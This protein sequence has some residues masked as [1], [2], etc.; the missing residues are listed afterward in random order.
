MSDSCTQ[1]QLSV[2]R[3]SDD[4]TQDER[5]FTTSNIPRP[6]RAPSTSSSQSRDNRSSRIPLAVGPGTRPN[7]SGAN[8]R[9]S[10]TPRRR[11]PQ[12]GGSTGLPTHSSSVLPRN[13]P[14]GS[15]SGYPRFI[16]GSA[17]R[18]SSL[19]RPRGAQRRPQEDQGCE[20][21]YNFESDRE[22]GYGDT[23]P[24]TSTELIASA[25]E[26]TQA[27]IDAEDISGHPVQLVLL[28][29]TLSSHGDVLAAMLEADLAMQEMMVSGEHD[30]RRHSDASVP[31][32]VMLVRGASMPDDDSPLTDSAKR[33]LQG[34]T[35]LRQSSPVTRR[36]PPDQ[37][38]TRVNVSIDDR[39]SA[40]HLH[41]S[42]T[43]WMAED[44]GN[45][46]SGTVRR[47][48]EVVQ[49]DVTQ[50]TH[51][52]QP[53]TH[54]FSDDDDND[55]TMSWPSGM[56][57]PDPEATFM[58]SKSWG[59]Q[60]PRHRTTQTPEDAQTQTPRDR[61][62]KLPSV[63]GQSSRSSLDLCDIDTS[64][65]S[66]DSNDST[67]MQVDTPGGATAPRSARQAAKRRKL[68]GFQSEPPNCDGKSVSRDSDRTSSALMR[69]MRYARTDSSRTGTEECDG[70][71]STLL[72]S[73]KD[74]T[75][76][77]AYLKEYQ[78]YIEAFDGTT[79]EP[80]AADSCHGD[81]LGDAHKMAAVPHASSRRYVR[82]ESSN[83][84][85]ESGMRSRVIGSE[86]SSNPNISEAN[87]GRRSTNGEQRVPR[88]STRRVQ[89]ARA[90]RQRPSPE[91]RVQAGRERSL[92]WH[93]R[94]QRRSGTSR[95]DNATSNTA[96][97]QTRNIPHSSPRAAHRRVKTLDFTQQTLCHQTTQTPLKLRFCIDGS[98]IPSGTVSLGDTFVI[99]PN[100]SLSSHAIQPW[101]LMGRDDLE[102]QASRDFAT[103]TFGQAYQQSHSHIETQTNELGL[104]KSMPR[105]SH[106][107][108]D[109]TQ[110]TTNEQTQTRGE[111]VELQP[112]I[113]IPPT[114]IRHST[115]HEEPTRDVETQ[116]D[117]FDIPKSKKEKK[118]REHRRRDDADA[119]SQSATVQSNMTKMD[120]LK[121]MLRQVRDLKSQINPAET[122]NTRKEKEARKKHKSKHKHKHKS[123]VSESVAD[124]FDGERE[125]LYT[126]R[127]LELMYKKPEEVVAMVSDPES[128][129]RRRHSFDSYLSERRDYDELRSRYL[130]R[131]RIGY[132][133]GRREHSAS[134]LRRGVAPPVSPGKLYDRPIY[135]PTYPG[136]GTKYQ[137]QPQLR[138]LYPPP[139]PLPAPLT[140]RMP[141]MTPVVPPPPP[142][143][144]QYA[145]P[146]G[147]TQLQLGQGAFRP[148]SDTEARQMATPLQQNASIVFI[149]NSQQPQGGV[150]V[151][152]SPYIVIASPY[153]YDSVSDSP[154]DGK[155]NA[156]GAGKRRDHKPRP[157]SARLVESAQLDSSI[158]KAT[159]AANE[160]KELTRRLK[161]K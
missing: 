154:H 71:N 142:A 151:P 26:V 72:R 8:G 121:F 140:P 80:F 41:R 107:L 42:D 75:A 91:L 60:T 108:D 92:T 115:T 101:Q 131:S 114:R 144:P 156:H 52:L 28:D 13:P 146:A 143:P 69:T 5:Y 78:E 120:I 88:S 40:G 50:S 2:L 35:P 43:M 87:P 7:R 39:S 106:I 109:A 116:R 59:T 119:V 125:K 134:P 49:H 55:D 127:R 21:V 67:F 157:S 44:V 61:R 153:R 45:L 97:T 123:D 18:S 161:H 4:G 110:T 133:P 113:D 147:A 33:A 36:L 137:T 62:R 30:G 58:S 126:K 25:D 135:R 22:S 79:T 32:R 10:A 136:V 90:G 6:V 132:P 65:A 73:A 100:D 37:S 95:G 117:I 152:Q 112:H 150:A 122:D 31:V 159:R 85:L 64:V 3:D 57:E 89:S 70:P 124:S 1:T 158:L 9:S 24:A 20:C 129:E 105:Y 141:R 155:E 53:N 54:L 139:P 23:L 12:P 102:I 96:A 47:Q 66:G 15:T 46:S 86:V 81:T 19:D 84:V 34:K 104:V 138:T 56:T 83:R 94:E 63:P 68:P 149:P 14:G 74:Q 130:P 160:M 98:S 128:R 77:P 17:N 99:D 82:P 148:I 38:L 48:V 16:V 11:L 103:Q 29:E 51:V 27:D 76:Q 93:N 145:V 118:K 111:A